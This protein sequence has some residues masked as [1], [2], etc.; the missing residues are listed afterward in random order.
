MLDKYIVQLVSSPFIFCFEIDSAGLNTLYPLTSSTWEL[1]IC[2]A[3]SSTE[4]LNLCHG[5]T[6]KQCK[7]IFK[8]WG[9]IILQFGV[10]MVF[11]DVIICHFD[12]IIQNWGTTVALCWLRG[13]LK[14]QNSAL[15]QQH[16]ELF[17]SSWSFNIKIL[18]CDVTMEHW[19]V[20]VQYYEGMIEYFD[21]IWWYAVEHCPVRGDI[22]VFVGHCDI[23]RALCCHNG[24]WWQSKL[25]QLMFVT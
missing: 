2:S 3:M 12:G 9:I 14:C 21:G 7:G 25:S 13:A 5:V 15:F 24:T 8:D 18:A 16:G 11:C 19:D 6:M 17:Q 1:Q 23:V 4:N 22:L 10:T 20:T